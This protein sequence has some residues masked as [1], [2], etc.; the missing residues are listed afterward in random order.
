MDEYIAEIRLFG[1]NF[2][3]RNWAFCE[4][5]LL[6]ISQ[7]QALFSLIGTIY[8]GDGQTTF[9]LP[10]LRGR[11]PLT[12]GNGPGLSSFNLGQKGGIEEQT[13]QEAYIPSHNHIAQINV[14]NQDGED[15]TPV[16]NF[17]AKNEDAEFYSEDPG[18]T[19]NPSSVTLADSGSY[20]PTPITNLEPTIALNYIIC[21]VGLYPSRN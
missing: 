16:G 5:Q 19:M 9:G 8:G 12:S 18:S 11:V 17:L 13:L 10:D 20:T 6:A 21:L 4:G 15:T 3:P 1:G 14:S 7:N 2:A